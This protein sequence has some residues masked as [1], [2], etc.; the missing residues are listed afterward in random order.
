MI[1]TLHEDAD[2]A[3]A[4]RA[5]ADLGLQVGAT[6]RNERGIV[7]LVLASVGVAP[8]ADLV[9]QIPEVATVGE[10]TSAHPR[11]DAHGPIARVG[12]QTISTLS[13]VL[14]SGP[15]AVE[16]EAQIHRIARE[17]AKRGATFLRGGAFKP[18]TSPYSFQ[19]CG[20][21]ALGWLRDAARENGMLAV[22]EVMSERD[23]EVVAE[24]A[25][26]LQIGT[27]NMYNYA[28]LKAV[29]ACGRAVL[30]KRSMSATIEEW[31]L[32][33]EYLLAHGAASVVF[34]ERGIRGFDNNTR[35]LLDLGA[36]ALLSHTYRLPVIVDPSHAAGRRDLVLPLASAAFAAGA[37]G[38]M[39]ETHDDPGNA[40][41]D[42][43]QAIAPRALENLAPYLRAPAP[44]PSVTAARAAASSPSPAP[45][46]QGPIS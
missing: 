15:C 22:T 26:L 31:L 45:L 30:L 41:S 1:L 40:R 11:V 37:A 23:V 25:E 32:A 16:S 43:A 3:A 14:M 27:R 10:T 13:P 18:R 36:V 12:T 44:A 19:G 28:L 17:I 42:G 21:D 7:H 8:A 35:N 39:I 29:G 38:V 9:R 6:E 34:C 5:L 33:G 2:V 46:T 4:K 20:R 24:H